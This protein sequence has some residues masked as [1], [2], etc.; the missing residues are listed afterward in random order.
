MSDPQCDR[1]QESIRVLRADVVGLEKLLR[2]E[3]LSLERLI[4][5]RLDESDK[6]LV[7]QSEIYDRRL[8][9]LNNEGRRVLDIQADMRD[10]YLRRDVYESSGLV[11]KQAL[12]AGLISLVVS[13]IVV[14]T[15]LLLR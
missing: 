4:D 13:T 7:K 15:T 10:N 3:M 11:W 5:R 6:A 14:G 8:E 1:N 9:G 2:A 12:I